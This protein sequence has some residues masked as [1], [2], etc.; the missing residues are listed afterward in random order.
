MSSSQVE[1]A[2]KKSTAIVERAIDDESFR[3]KLNDDPE[4]TLRA[5]GL[6]GPR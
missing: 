2:R 4:E 5:E 3:K 6:P 1:E